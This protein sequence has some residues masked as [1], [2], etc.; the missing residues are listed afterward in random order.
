MMPQEVLSQKGTVKKE[1]TLSTVNIQNKCTGTDAKLVGKIND[2]RKVNNITQEYILATSIN[3][4]YPLVICNDTQCYH[5]GNMIFLNGKSYNVKIT[6]CNLPGVRIESHEVGKVNNDVLLYKI[7]FRSRR[8]FP[9][10]YR[11]GSARFRR[12]SVGMTSYVTSKL[13]VTS[14]QF[15]HRISSRGPVMFMSSHDLSN[16]RL[17]HK[18]FVEVEYFSNQKEVIKIQDEGA[19]D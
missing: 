13:T 8:V 19:I 10:E 14:V 12:L 17:G 5:Y 9:T 4:S 11:I 18:Y 7:R 16:L 1:S 2:T 15:R 3:I 6:K